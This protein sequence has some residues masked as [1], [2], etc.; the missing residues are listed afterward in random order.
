MSRCAS[1]G[2]TSA[3]MQV[4][5]GVEPGRGVEP[6]T[7]SLRVVF[8]YA[9]C[10]LHFYAW[11]VEPNRPRE[12]GECMKGGRLESHSATLEA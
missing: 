7:C 10:K 6:L 3:K 2:Q 12:H 8:P 4:T 5:W 11:T 9:L 1:V